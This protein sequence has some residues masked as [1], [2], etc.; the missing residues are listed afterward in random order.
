VAGAGPVAIAAGRWS[1]LVAVVSGMRKSL[2]VGLPRQALVWDSRY[3]HLAN[4][5]ELWVKNDIS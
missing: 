3:L 5:N 4:D 2:V 1:W